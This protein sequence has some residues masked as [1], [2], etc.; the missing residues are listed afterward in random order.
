MIVTGADKCINGDNAIAARPVLHHD[1]LGP[2]LTEAIR[3]QPCAD[4][5][6]AAGPEREYEFYRARRPSLL[7]QSLLG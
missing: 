4:I 3:E 6:A 1:R 2:A 7:G 5:G